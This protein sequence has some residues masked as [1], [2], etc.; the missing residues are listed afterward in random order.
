[1][2]RSGPIKRNTPLKRGSSIKRSPIAKKPKKT[3][4]GLAEARKAAFARSAGRCE[5]QWQGCQQSAQ[6]AHHRLLRSQGGQHTA[7]NLLS[8]CFSCH[9]YIHANPEQAYE[10]GHM[11]HREAG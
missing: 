7:D 6:H 1:M 4:K 11:L 2:K 9:A 5:A 3:E 8:V 10:R